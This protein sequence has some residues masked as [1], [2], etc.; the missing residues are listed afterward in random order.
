MNSTELLEYFRAQ[1]VDEIR[2]Y[3][4][5]DDEIIVFMNEAQLKFCRLTEGISDVSTPEVVNVPVTTGEILA[6]THPSILN[7]RMA[8]LAS[9]GRKVEITNHTDV[10]SWANY[11]GEVRQ[12]II[13]MEENVVRWGATPAIDDEVN[14]MVFRLPLTDITDFDQDF[15]IHPKHHVSFVHW[16]K[17]LAYLKDDTEVF[18]KNASDKAKAQFEGYCDLVAAEQRRYRQ[19]VRV[20]AYGGI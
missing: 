19:K 6:E 2:P 8:L 14:L 12:M 5:S 18:D 4:W 10:V 3:Q 20:V 13:G 1:V 15:E 9:T 16:M 7:F 17:H 11:T